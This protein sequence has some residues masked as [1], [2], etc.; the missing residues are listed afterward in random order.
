MSG[1]S[2]S[3]GVSAL[4]LK[5]VDGDL[6]YISGG[7]EQIIATGIELPKKKSY[8]FR[9]FSGSSGINYIAGFYE[10]GSVAD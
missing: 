5:V 1:N 6:I 2:G 9:S 7:V 3:G 8:S 4:P 10:L